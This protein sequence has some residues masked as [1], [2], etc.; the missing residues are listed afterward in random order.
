MG[1]T[2]R[3]L[4]ATATINIALPLIKKDGSQAS[5]LALNTLSTKIIKPDGTALAGYTEATFTEPNSDGI[6]NIQFAS[7]AGVKAFTLEDQNNPYTVTVDSS[8]ADVEPTAIEVWIVSRLPQENSKEVTLADVHSDLAGDVAQVA[9]VKAQ[10]DKILFDASNYIKSAPQTAVTVNP[11]QA[12]GGALQP[13]LPIKA[14]AT[15]E[16]PQGD[17]Y[18]IPW[19]IG[20]AAAKTDAK[21]IFIAKTNESDSD[22]AAAISQEITIA[23]PANVAGMNVLTTAMTA[24]IASY[25]AR[26]K[27][28]DADGLS[29]PLTVWKGRLNVVSNV[30]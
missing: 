8:T 18:P 22:A 16:A 13:L 28:V 30:G 2:Q 20:S 3:K 5:G 9:L 12:L 21:F 14:T 6:Y 10:T 4:Q 26:I 23:D 27:R 11:A 15:I 29:N 17:A 25:H 1:N 24:A 7:N 19:A